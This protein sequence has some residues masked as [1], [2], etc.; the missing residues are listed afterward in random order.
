MAARCTVCASGSAP[1]LAKLVDAGSPAKEAALALGLGYESVKRHLRADHPPT[2]WTVKATQP[3]PT[4]R[5][6]NVAASVGA[7]GPR[8]RRA[9]SNLTATETFREAFE[10]E[11]QDHQ[12]E[13]MEDSRN[14]LVLKGRQIGMSTAGAALAISVARSGPG[15]DAVIVSPSMKQSTEVAL[16]SRLGLWNLGE[17]LTKDSTSE[18]MLENGSRILSLAGTARAVRGYSAALLVVDEAAWVEEPTWAAARP[19]VSA[20]KGRVII[21]S[22]PGL[23]VGWFFD[24]WQATP[25]D[26]LRMRVRSDEVAS[27]SREFLD[28]EQASMSPELFAQEYLAQFAAA[29]A[30]DLWTEDEW[31]ALIRKKDPDTTGQEA[32]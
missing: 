10:M 5:I 17:K 29:P 31:R 7:T 3:T 32:T 24:L 6:S 19:M 8:A 20:T 14:T 30:A 18:L 27:V 21:Q 28:A 25:A 12:V 9:L 11:P 15:R 16:K 13:Y 22:T 2:R 4:R 26:W 23:P 1:A